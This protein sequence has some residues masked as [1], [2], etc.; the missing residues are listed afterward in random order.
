MYVLANH[1]YKSTA[2]GGSVYS[3]TD[4]NGVPA[5]RVAQ[6]VSEAAALRFVD[7]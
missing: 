6:D 4:L 3:A 2:V 1:P 7:G 5:V